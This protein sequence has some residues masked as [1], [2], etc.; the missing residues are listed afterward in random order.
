MLQ[1][2][3][4]RVPASTA[5]RRQQ[6]CSREREAKPAVARM[7]KR[8]L[9]LIGSVVLLVLFLPLIAVVALLIKW[10]DGGP[11][12]Y[13]RRVVGPKREFDAFKLRSMCLNADE[14]L[15][16]DSRLRTE[17]EQNFKLKTDPRITPV[18]RVIRRLSLDELPQ[19]FNVLKGEMSLVGPRMITP[20]ELERFADAR[21]IFQ[22]MKPGMTGYWQVYGRQEVPYA[23]RVE[24]ELYYVVHWSLLLD[25][26]ILMKTPLTVVRGAGAY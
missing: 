17:F 16:R 4:L 14:V 22:E 3:E 19:L 18:G 10:H 2:A 20:Q 8:A 23:R 15:Q 1:E 7:L 12:V 21:W 11:I 5:E 13:R 9:D 24:M 6:E 25:F 26:K